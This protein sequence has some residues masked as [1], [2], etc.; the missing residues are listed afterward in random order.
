MLP[1]D[2]TSV[3]PE[4]TP[5]V[6]PPPSLRVA[7]RPVTVAWWVAAALALTCASSAARAAKP[8]PGPSAL[9]YWPRQPGMAWLYQDNH[10]Q[11]RTVRIAS[12]TTLDGQ[13][14]TVIEYVGADGAVTSRGYCAVQEGAILLVATEVPP[15]RPGAG[16]RQMS[17]P[18]LLYP[19]RLAQGQ[20][21][22]VHAGKSGMTMTTVRGEETVTVP[23]G[24]YHAVVVV[25][26][27]PG[28]G[29]ATQWLAPQVGLVRTVVSTGGGTPLTL[30][31]VRRTTA[32]A[33]AA[34]TAP[35][36]ASG[37]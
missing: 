27:S 34:Q 25:R 35:P 30:E 32:E 31:L 8:P 9:D 15:G 1:V 12:Q 18:V 10:G 28:G 5:S 3:V 24:T 20:S 4:A 14:V 37:Q 16:R 2:S 23:A 22:N 17:P 36:H 6:L 7:R 29:T 26:T 19:A 33:A 11:Q 21:W 13:E